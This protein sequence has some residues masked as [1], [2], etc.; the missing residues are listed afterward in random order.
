M[1]K[2]QL[3]E[4]IKDAI[5]T[6]CACRICKGLRQIWTANLRAEAR[7]LQIELD[8][9]KDQKSK[10]LETSINLNNA[11]ENLEESTKNTVI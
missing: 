2:I 11:K 3:E 7:L 6:Q 5:N 9:M 8:M 1:D 10:E 4:I